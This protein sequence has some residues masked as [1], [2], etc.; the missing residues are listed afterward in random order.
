MGWTSKKEEESENVRMREG[1]EG[2]G[3]ER[4]LNLLPYIPTA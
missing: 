4:K 2:K 1:R 3:L